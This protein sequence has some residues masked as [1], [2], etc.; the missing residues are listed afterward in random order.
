M[1][2]LAL[3]QFS[4]AGCLPGSVRS[5]VR[6][7]QDCV[8]APTLSLSFRFSSRRINFSALITA[9]HQ[10]VRTC[11]TQCSLSF[12]RMLTCIVAMFHIVLSRTSLRLV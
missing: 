4:F 6:C 11:T 1:F 12:L 5:W 9:F 10:F 2:A 8:Q 7:R 3:S